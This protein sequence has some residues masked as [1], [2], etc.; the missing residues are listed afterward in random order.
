VRYQPVTMTDQPDTKQEYV[1]IALSVNASAGIVS[2]VLSPASEPGELNIEKIMQLLKEQQV[3]HWLVFE[4]AIEDVL[5]KFKKNQPSQVTIAEKR[6]ALVDLRISDSNM[7]ATLYILPAKGGSP[8]TENQLNTLLDDHKIVKNRII[9]Q[10]FQEAVSANKELTLTIAR[11]KPSIPGTNSRF[12]P[13]IDIP[14]EDHGPQENEDG[15]VDF[16]AG[17]EYLTVGDG[18]PL[19]ERTPPTPGK[20]GMDVLGQILSALPGREIQFSDKIEGVRFDASNPNLLIADR[21]GHPVFFENGVRVDNTLTFDNVD[22]STGHINFDGSVLVKGDIRPDMKVKVSGDLVVKGVVE[23]AFIDVGHNLTIN[24]GILGEAQIEFDPETELNDVQYECIVS[25]GGNLEARYANLVQIKTGGDIFIKEYAFNCDI[26][27]QSAV[28]LGQ[29][30]GKGNLVGGQCKAR[31][32]VAARTLGNKAYLKTN[33]QVGISQAEYNKY[34]D[35]LFLRRQ[36]L[37]QARNLRKILD[38]LKA[39]GQTEQLGKLQIDKAKKIHHS[40]LK[41]Q[42]HLHQIDDKLLELQVLQIDSKEPNIKATGQCFP[43]CHL[44]IN[45]S[46]MLNKYEHRAITFVNQGRKITA[47]K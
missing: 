5:Y 18:T 35:L 34:Q 11:G 33:I 7:V 1:A 28:Y 40:L 45:G 19:L 2:A 15:T 12:V 17:K 31:R 29:K 26:E 24:G 23:R 4:G 10:A 36:R 9:Q 47:Q 32:E 42:E 37:D 46:V 3:D 6:D 27:S 16:L 13:L 30:G 39:L 8:V 21:G 25:A 20:V 14:T 22:L 41:L 38:D 44:I 43:N